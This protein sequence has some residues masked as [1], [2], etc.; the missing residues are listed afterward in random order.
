MSE[1]Y[2]G[3]GNKTKLSED[4]DR[5]K[6]DLSTFIGQ[7]S[8]AEEVSILVQVSDVIK[9]DG[10]IWSTATN[11]VASTL[12]AQSNR[13]AIEF[14]V[15]PNTKYVIQNMSAGTSQN[16]GIGFFANKDDIYSTSVLYDAVQESVDGVGARCTV[17]TTPFDC[18]YVRYIAYLN[19]N[20]NKQL[21]E[22][23]EYDYKLKE[24]KIPTEN[25]L[26]GDKNKKVA[27]FG[28][29]IT[30]GR[31]GGESGSTENTFAVNLARKTGYIV[32]N[33]GVGSQGWVTASSDGNNAYG[34]IT[35]HDLTGYD[36]V[37]LQYGTNDSSQT[38]GTLSDTSGTI[39]G[40]MYRCVNYLL[41]TYPS[42]TV[43][44][45]GQINANYG[46][47][48]DYNL[49]NIENRYNYFKAFCDKYHLIWIDT[50]H[51]S[52]ING[53]NLEQLL[54]DNVHPNE[55]GYKVLSPFIASQIAQY[56]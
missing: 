18:N 16:Y 29:S 36:V 2:D 21:E 3:F 9:H 24:E 6:D 19:N 43:I 34:N 7:I 46:T 56:I 37:T 28:D 48:P 53:F 50:I 41:T 32:D 33:F 38:L 54:G 42:I 5:L 23:I 51:N 4:V 35:S 31:I 12:I 13:V 40:E 27:M 20:Y 15:K 22:V 47:S 10:Y 8:N 52:P 17:F 39:L 11:M 14:P 25:F 44:I 26:K 55:N 1:L 30:W 45:I 49:S